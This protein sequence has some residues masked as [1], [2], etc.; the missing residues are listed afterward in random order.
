LIIDDSDVFMLF[1]KILRK[2]VVPAV[3][4]LLLLVPGIYAQEEAAVHTEAVTLYGVLVFG[5]SFIRHSAAMIYIHFI[6]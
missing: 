3:I 4:I 1:Q 2:Q 6:K 5:R